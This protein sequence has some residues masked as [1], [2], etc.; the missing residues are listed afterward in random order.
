MRY[1][2]Q[3]KLYEL[4]FDLMESL[5]EAKPSLPRKFIS[6]YFA[7]RIQEPEDEKQTEK[8]DLQ[9]SGID[10]VDLRMLDD[11]ATPMDT[12]DIPRSI[13]TSETVDLTNIPTQ[14]FGLKTSIDLEAER[15]LKAVN[16]L[17]E[18][19]SKMNINH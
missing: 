15:A 16:D 12:F 5:L 7:N 8:Q 11:G 9:D 18:E 13:E 1:V 10:F 3:V 14:D 19:S 4:I 2:K 17:I 6:D